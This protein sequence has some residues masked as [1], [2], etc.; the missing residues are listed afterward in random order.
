MWG[1]GDSPELT[2][3]VIKEISFYYFSKDKAIT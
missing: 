3:E 2:D 1:E